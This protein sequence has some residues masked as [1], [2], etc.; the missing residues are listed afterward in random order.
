MRLWEWRLLPYLPTSQ[1]LAQ[2]REIDLIW[3]DL[4]NGKKTNHILINYI[5]EY[6][7]YLTELGG[8]YWF[9]KTEFNKRG[10][11]FKFSENFINL[12]SYFGYY[13]PFKYHH[14]N[15]YLVQCFYNLQ[16]KYDRGQKDFTKDIFDKLYYFMEDKQ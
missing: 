11:V 13:V 12:N 5:W 9:L 16:E 6:D 8:Y 1:L 14:N 7:D 3:K 4:A 15:R 2:K 10:Y